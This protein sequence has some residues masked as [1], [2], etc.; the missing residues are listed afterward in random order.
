MY[1][2]ASEIKGQTSELVKTTEHWS[3]C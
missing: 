3:N 2:T 1:C